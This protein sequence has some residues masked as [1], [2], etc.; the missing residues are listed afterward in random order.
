VKASAVLLEVDRLTK[1]F[2]G[3][4]AVADVSFAVAPGEILGIFGPNGS[5]KTTLLSLISGVLA[6]TAGR[7]VWKGT[8]IEGAKP[9]R[10]AAAGV[11]KT[12]QNPQLFLELPVEENVAI[13]SHLGLRRHHGS[14]R[15]A[16]LLPWRGRTEEADMRARIARVLELC[17]LADVRAEP[18]ASLSY[19]QEKMLGVAMAMMCEPELL[20]LDE[21][22][23]GL[24]EDEI[25]SLEEVLRDLRQAHTTLC[26]I[27]HKVDFL[28]RVADRAI[29]L[30]QGAKIAEGT[31]GEVLRD[32]QVVEAYLGRHHAGA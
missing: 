20:L 16:E 15:L 30:Q 21:P 2:G 25:R 7:I 12:F 9:H 27:D 31:P 5:G 22:A 24:G 8:P 14:R 13:A 3:L 1:R 32:P 6:P 28:G 11:V 10:I 17:R 18:A 26:I 23:S 19:G 29:A 4:T